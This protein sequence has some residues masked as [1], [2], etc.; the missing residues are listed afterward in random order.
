MGVLPMIHEKPGNIL[1][2]QTDH[3]P[4]DVIGTVIEDFYKAGAFN[5]QVISSVT[6]KNRPGYLFFIDT[7]PGENSQIESIII[8]DL[9]ATG[10]HQL[11]S[12]HRH[13][14]TEIWHREVVFDTPAGP[15]RHMA[16]VKVVMK[17]PEQM[18]PEHSS[19]VAARE[20]LRE[21]GA[22][23]SLKEISESIIRQ[24]SANLKQSQ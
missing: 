6:K 7:A 16:A 20:A 22:N 17:K 24:V 3:N 1:L 9:G 21:K 5:V 14:A 23:L 11:G 12:E 4:G 10:W 8:N 2:V 13:I 15:Y 18:R 19:C